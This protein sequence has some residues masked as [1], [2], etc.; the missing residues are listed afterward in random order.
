MAFAESAGGGEPAS[1]PESGP[2]P[3]MRSWVPL[4]AVCAGY[5]MVILDVTVINVAVPV[6][7][8]ELSASLTGIQWITDGYTL[9]FAG[10]LLGGGALGDRLGN[11]RISCTGVAV[12]TVSSAACAFAPSAPV[13]VDARVVEGLG[14]ALIV[15][16]SLALLQQGYPAAAARS[17]AFGSGAPSRASR[18]RRGRCWAGCWSPPWAGGGCS[19]STCP[20]ASPAR[21]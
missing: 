6:I 3:G 10:F 9:V 4:L 13:L 11:R 14:A 1:S 5:F 8:R 15:P 7:G 20:S 12:F 21:C 16:G 2:M 17:R 18:P 19:S